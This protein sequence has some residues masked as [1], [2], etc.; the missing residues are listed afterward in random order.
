MKSSITRLF[1]E[2]VQFLSSITD[3]ENICS[4]LFFIYLV[5]MIAANDEPYG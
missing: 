2:Q 1:R 3:C 4:L 5:I